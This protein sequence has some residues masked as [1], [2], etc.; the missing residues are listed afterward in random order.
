[1]ERGIFLNVNQP[2][3]PVG[4]TKDVLLLPPAS[5]QARGAYVQNGSQLQFQFDTPPVCTDSSSKT[6]VVAFYCGYATVTALDAT[7][8]L[9][10]DEW[11]SFERR[12]RGVPLRAR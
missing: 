5:G 7:R 8:Q 6:D 12:L 9:T 10:S 4:Q 1:M 11:P 3:L 2:A